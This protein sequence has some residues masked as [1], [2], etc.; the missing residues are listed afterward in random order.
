[1]RSQLL[2]NLVLLGLV[3]ALVLFAVYQPGKPPL[4]KPF[5]L[6]QAS[7][8]TINKIRIA[9]KHQEDVVLR[10]EHGQW[11]MVKPF[12]IHANPYRTT[13]ILT[14]LRAESAMQL[15][16]KQQD[17][18][19]FKLDDPRVKLEL[20]DYHFAFGDTNPLDQ[21]RY[22]LFNDI[23]YLIGD[24][25][26]QH[27]IAEP[28][29]FVSTQLLPSEVRLSEIR[30]PGYHLQLI[31]G[32]W[33]VTPE[34]PETS[35]DAISQLVDAWRRA[36]ALAVRAHQKG[37]PLGTVY[38][39]T[40]DGGG[41]QFAIMAQTPELILARLDFAIQYHLS[42]AAGARLLELEEHPAPPE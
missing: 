19:R 23:L 29:N 38:L 15:N 11:W 39:N 25:V 1:M 33:S 5:R 26:Y 35:S 27:L 36:E 22:V 17:L 8:D 20:D 6:T 4:S 42:E 40:E 10:K 24:R 7:Q 12:A 37:T 14:V 32:T 13:A 34:L 3:L 30:L 18:A 2:L 31:E 16:A 41:V 9:R 21:R 28:A